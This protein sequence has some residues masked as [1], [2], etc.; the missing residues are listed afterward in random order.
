MVKKK[1]L[2]VRWDNEAIESL[3]DIYE[4]IKADSPSGALKVRQT[5]LSLA[6]SLGDF[7][8]KYVS[9][10]SLKEEPGNYRSVSKWN[11]KLIYEETEKEVIVIMVFHTSQN[12]EKI[13][14]HLK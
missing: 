7:P 6:R 1:R 5:L 4:Y 8:E 11:Y 14:K 13:K 9:E 2:P 10:P 3:R 12:P